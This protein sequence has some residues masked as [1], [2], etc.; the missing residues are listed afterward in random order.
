MQIRRARFDRSLTTIEVSPS[1]VSYRT[2][3]PHGHRCYKV[4]LLDPSNPRVSAWTETFEPG[5]SGPKVFPL[6][7]LLADAMSLVYDALRRTNQPVPPL[8]QS[9]DLSV[10]LTAMPKNGLA[11]DPA[12]KGD[13]DPA[14]SPDALFKPTSN[15]PQGDLK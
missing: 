13:V 14:V 6:G 5:H 8:L 11:T 15:V 1:Q 10:V 7:L 3:T 9:Y 12:P 4:F 2:R